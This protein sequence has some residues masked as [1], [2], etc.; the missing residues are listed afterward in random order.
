MTTEHDSD[1]PSPP[2][3]TG[4]PESDRTLTPGPGAMV[5]PE[6]AGPYDFDAFADMDEFLPALEEIKA[7][8][9]EYRAMMQCLTRTCSNI[10]RRMLNA[11][12][13]AEETA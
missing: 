3:S 12:I 5:G 8:D 10:G 11:L 2:A 13:Q 9:E 7:M 6:M 4:T 1:G